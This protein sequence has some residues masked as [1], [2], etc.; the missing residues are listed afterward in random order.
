VRVVLPYT[1]VHPLTEESIAEHVPDIERVFVGRKD[2]AYWELLRDL[3]SAGETFVLIEHDMELHSAVLPEF[4][5]CRQPW[6]VFPYPGPTPPRG[7]SQVEH[8][9][10]LLY[11]SL[12]CTRFSAALIAK[13]PR[14]IADLPSRHWERL[15]AEIAPA[16]M[17]LGYQVHVHRPAVLQHHVWNGECACGTGH[18]PYRVDQWGRFRG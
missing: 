2:H 9:D 13:R 11:R 14:F 15:D 1:R 6:C 3:W 16:L 5:A 12:G 17:R 4:D 18:K 7:W 8:G 10:P